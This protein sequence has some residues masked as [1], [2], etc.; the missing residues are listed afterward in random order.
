MHKWLAY[1][2]IDVIGRSRGTRT[3]SFTGLKIS[4]V[5]GHS[6]SFP[7]L[8]S[9]SFPSLSTFEHCK[10]RFKYSTVEKPFTYF[11]PMAPFSP[12]KAN[13]DF[14]RARDAAESA[15]QFVTDRSMIG[16]LSHVYC[17]DFTAWILHPRK[18]TSAHLTSN[19]VQPL[20]Q[21][22]SPRSLSRLRRS[23]S[24]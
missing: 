23:P 8:R 21:P 13:L 15:I 20:I 16:H 1:K 2:R 3:H 7:V 4:A 14:V 24:L 6:S 22:Y 11:S 18:C 9:S 5:H 17:K 12:I 19:C 10:N